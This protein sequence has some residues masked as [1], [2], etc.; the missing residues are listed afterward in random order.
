MPSLLSEILSFLLSCLAL[1]GVTY[2]TR[3]MFRNSNASA[4]LIEM[5]LRLR[6]GSHPG[7]G[8]KWMIGTARASA[9]HLSLM[10]GNGRR[11]AVSVDELRATPTRTTGLAESF[12]IAY[13]FVVIEL[14][15]GTAII[16]AAM[17]PES[18]EWLIARLTGEPTSAGS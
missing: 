18:V 14:I 17:E 1:G 5:G 12:Q 3:K 11:A 8:D 15:S 6:E 9:G 2:A 10:D 7:L 4:N 16:E 13:G